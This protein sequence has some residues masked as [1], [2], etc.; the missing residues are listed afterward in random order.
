MRSLS[1][2]QVR[3][4]KAEIDFFIDLLL[5]DTDSVEMADMRKF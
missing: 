4:L 1:L 5:A 3:W 2:K